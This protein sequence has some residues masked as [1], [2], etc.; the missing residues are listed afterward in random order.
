[1]QVTDALTGQVFNEDGM[2]CSHW[3]CVFGLDIE[4]LSKVR[5]LLIAAA[6]EAAEL[7]APLP[8]PFFQIVCLLGVQQRHDGNDR[9]Q[10]TAGLVDNVSQAL[11]VSVGK[12]A[13]ERRC[14]NRIDGQNRKQDRMTTERFFI[15]ADDAAAGFLDCFCRLRGSSCRFLQLTLCWAEAFGARLS[16]A[17]TPPDGARLTITRVPF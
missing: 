2:S 5:V 16:L 4:D 11:V 7:A 9:I 17:G 13:L 10:E 12:I 6:D 15:P 8:I 1:M 14:F 3:C